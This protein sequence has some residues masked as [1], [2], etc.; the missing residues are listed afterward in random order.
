MQS[1]ASTRISISPDSHNPVVDAL[2]RT[3]QTIL[4]LRKDQ[5][6]RNCPTQPPMS[7]VLIRRK[8]NHSLYHC[9]VRGCL[10]FTPA[11][12]SPT[13]TPRPQD[14][15]IASQTFIS[16]PGQDPR[17]WSL[18]PR[19]YW[20]F[21]P[22]PFWTMSPGNDRCSIRVVKISKGPVNKKS[23]HSADPL[24]QSEARRIQ[25]ILR[26]A[27]PLL[28]L[29]AIFVFNPSI[30]DERNQKDMLNSS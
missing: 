2:K 28:W 25:E 29:R 13:F 23:E 30:I 15:K 20:C 8:P 19:A 7:F 12:P 26:T 27:L 10:L 3:V 6:N 1:R 11:L 9:N 5:K 4:L 14:V 16:R 18:E 22:G 17:V 21:I 24:E